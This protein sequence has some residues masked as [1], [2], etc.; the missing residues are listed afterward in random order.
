MR[1]IFCGCCGRLIRK[2]FILADIEDIS[3]KTRSGCSI[4]TI[5]QQGAI[6]GKQ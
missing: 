4:S 6:G 1:V 2:G 5:T 3:K